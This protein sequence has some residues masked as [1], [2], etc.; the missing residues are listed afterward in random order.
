[1]EFYGLFLNNLRPEIKSGA[2]AERRFFSSRYSGVHMSL[3]ASS[4]IV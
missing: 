4:A 3:P 1:M 2:A